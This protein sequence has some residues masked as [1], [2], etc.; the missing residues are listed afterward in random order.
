VLYL[1]GF[2]F[3]LFFFIFKFLQPRP[4]DFNIANHILHE[5]IIRDT[6]HHLLIS[7][8]GILL[9]CPQI[10]GGFGSPTFFQRARS[11]LGFEF[12]VLLE[13]D[14]RRAHG[15]AEEVNVFFGGVAS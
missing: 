2:F 9:L 11:Q 14:V 4:T 13:T 7:G 1:F 5:L 10:N 8:I 12:V 3:I 15:D 6:P